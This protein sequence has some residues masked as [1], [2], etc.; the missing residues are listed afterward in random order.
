MTSQD[1]SR[2]R[3][4][5]RVATAAAITVAPGW[6]SSA[7]SAESEKGKPTEFQIACMTLPYSAYPLKRALEG[8]A[9][10][11][12]RYVAW[13]TSH[14]EG[15][16]GRVPVLPADA[17][18]AQ[19]EALAKRCRAMGLTP[20]MM[21]SGVSVEAE[22]TVE[23]HRK[24]VAQAA[25]AGIPQILSMGNTKPGRRD[26]WLKNLG[27]IGPIARAAGVTVV[28]KQ[29][30]GETAT[31]EATAGILRE[32][33]DEGIR[34][35]YDAGNVLDYMNID[36]IPDV[37]TCASE[38]RSFCIKDHRN[39]PKD[40]DCSPGFGE[41]D[42]YR[43]LSPFVSTGLEMPLAFENISIPLLP[44]PA[45]PEEIDHRARRAREYV[46]AV[47]KGLQL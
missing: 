44:A 8:I 12:F 33:G 1:L 14:N 11:G 40:E 9:D 4:F 20:I 37:L 10:A 22:D 32:V 34:I 5:G 24:R 43:L 28:V 42:H 39:F 21:F 27:A 46:E 19:A 30:G 18:P 36:P 15:E 3:F 47:V 29:H 2:R 26:L 16:K 23:T 13:G 6:P 41:I 45:T 17:P 7:V 25:A 31:G 35:S 38:I